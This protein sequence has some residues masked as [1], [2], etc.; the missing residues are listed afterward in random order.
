MVINQVSLK[1]SNTNALSTTTQ[2]YTQGISTKIVTVSHKYYFNN[3]TEHII[4]IRKYIDNDSN[5][6]SKGNN[7]SV[8]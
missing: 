8:R 7:F 4:L 1:T 2:N 6:K 3:E 5:V